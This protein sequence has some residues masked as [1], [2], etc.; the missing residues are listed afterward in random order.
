MS[1]EAQV[2]LNLTLGNGATFKMDGMS[3]LREDLIYKKNTNIS[4]NVQAVN[5]TG[6]SVGGGALKNKNGR[7]GNNSN[8]EIIPGISLMFFKRGWKAPD[9]CL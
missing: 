9:V 7:L 1:S 3:T 4:T 8:C 5:R 6:Y 2:K